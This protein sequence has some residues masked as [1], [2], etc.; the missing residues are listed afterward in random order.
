PVHRPARP[1]PGAAGD[2]TGDPA[3]GGGPDA[4]G[5]AVKT[6]G[7]TSKDEPGAS[8]RPDLLALEV[9]G[10]ARPVGGVG[11]AA[12]LLLVAVEPVEHDPAGQAQP[13]VVPAPGAVLGMGWVAMPG[14]AAAD[15]VEDVSPGV[16]RIGAGRHREGMAGPLLGVFLGA[17]G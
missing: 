3:G 2:D 5:D 11:A 1:L 16:R 10:D 6:H 14:R 8:S 7:A 13:L 4:V 12:A 15:L 9:L 17:G